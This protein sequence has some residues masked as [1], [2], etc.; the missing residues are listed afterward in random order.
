[1]APITIRPTHADLS[2]ANAISAH[3]GSRTE[4]AAEFLTWGADEHILCALAAGWWL[5]CRGKNANARRASDH[6]F[7]TTVVSSGLPH[8]LKM[9]FD[10]E[11]PDHRPF[12]ALAGCPVLRQA[13]RRISIW[14]CRT[15]GALASAASTLPV[16]QRNVIWSIGAGLVAT[17]VI[18]L[19][20][21]VKPSLSICRAVSR[22]WTISA[23]PN[24][25]RRRATATPNR[26]AINSEPRG[27]SR[28]ILLKMLNGIPG[29]RP[30]SI[31][32]LTRLTVPFTASETSAMVDF[33]SG[34]G[35]KPS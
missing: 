29:F 30:A 13:A 34:T 21:I 14:P 19:A 10:Q 33:G 16:K 5:Y 7:L 6:I 2:V 4:R 12:R 32:P 28:A 24:H 1:M 8:I 17:R 35:S 23:R 25:Y 27:A 31:A 15:H 20:H 11:R 22:I 26:N 3:T 18:L 9:V